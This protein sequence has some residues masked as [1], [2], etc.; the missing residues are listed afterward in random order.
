MRLREDYRALSGAEKAA[1]FMLALG[2]EHAHVGVH[3]CSRANRGAR[4]VI[5]QV[6]I[7]ADRW[8]KPCNGSDRWFGHSKGDHAE[9]FHVLSDTFHAQNIEQLQALWCPGN[10]SFA[11]HTNA[12]EVG[13]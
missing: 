2:E 7:Q 8:G 12:I 5:G 11:R 13:I 6:L 10:Q 4:A 9:R 3:L 1:I